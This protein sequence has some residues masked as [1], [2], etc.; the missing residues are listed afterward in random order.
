VSYEVYNA[1][2]IVIDNIDEKVKQIQEY[3]GAGR[4]RISRSIAGYVGK[5]KVCSLPDSS[6]QTLHKTWSS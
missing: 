2:R 5:S 3:I 6:L 4:A 1:L